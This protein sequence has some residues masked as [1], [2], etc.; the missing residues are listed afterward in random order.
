M[1]L[2]NLG[3]SRVLPLPPAIRAGLAGESC[4]DGSGTHMRT[5]QKHTGLSMMSFTLAIP[6]QFPAKRS[7]GK[8]S[9]LPRREF[10]RQ[11]I[12]FTG[13]SAGIEKIFPFF[14]CRQGIFAMP[15]RPCYVG[16]TLC[17]AEGRSGWNHRRPWANRSPS[18]GRS[19]LMKRVARRTYTSGAG[20]AASFA[21]CVGAGATH[22]SQAARTPMNA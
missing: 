19:F 7:A 15:K 8:K 6:Y 9:S 10:C 16:L 20:R 22:R 2:S 4:V 13:R 3:L 21:L 1:P 17:S 11:A 18:S 5:Y 14:P 12:D